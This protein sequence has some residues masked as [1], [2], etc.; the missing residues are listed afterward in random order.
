[1]TTRTELED[2]KA[3]LVAYIKSKLHAQ[4]WHAIAD[5]AMDLR[6]IDA[7]LSLMN[8]LGTALNMA[9]I[10][11]TIAATREMLNKDFNL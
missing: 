6:E 11:A 4:D 9:D 5:A 1:M 2:G 3:S 7:K 8:E 10:T